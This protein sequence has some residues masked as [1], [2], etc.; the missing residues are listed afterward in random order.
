MEAKIEAVT[1]EEVEGESPI[2]YLAETEL[3]ILKEKVS[4]YQMINWS[5]EMEEIISLKEIKEILNKYQDVISKGNHNIRNCELIEYAIKLTDD[6][7]ITYRL[8]K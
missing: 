3:L 5:K 4:I 6:I 8:R 2:G 7:L 1:W